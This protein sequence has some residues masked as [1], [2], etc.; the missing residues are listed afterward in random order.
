MT[1][2]MSLINSKHEIEAVERYETT[3]RNRLNALDNSLVELAGVGVNVDIKIE[4]CE[5][6]K[7]KIV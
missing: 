2:E 7:E 5:N 4:E 3:L 6:E 1:K